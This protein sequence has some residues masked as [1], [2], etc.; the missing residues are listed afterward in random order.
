[1]TQRH[2]HTHAQTLFKSHTHSHTICRC[3]Q[4]ALDG[5]S[6]RA[7]AE[8]PGRMGGALP[9]SGAPWAAFRGRVGGTH[10]GRESTE[11]HCATPKRTVFHGIFFCSFLERASPNFSNCRAMNVLEFKVLRAFPSIVRG[12]RQHLD[13]DPN[14]WQR[15]IRWSIRWS[16]RW[17]ELEAPSWVVSFVRTLQ[18]YRLQHAPCFPVLHS[19]QFPPVTLD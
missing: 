11:N 6:F 5:P 2:T 18:L 9:R 14:D 4:A 8:A 17:F 3:S 10:G 16:L 13:S 1:M 7:P 15:S 12:C 19:T